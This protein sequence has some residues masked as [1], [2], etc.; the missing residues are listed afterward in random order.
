M[1]IVIYNKKYNVAGIFLP[2]RINLFE[3]KCIGLTPIA[4]HTTCVTY[5]S[6]ESQ[7]S[8]WAW[9]ISLKSAPTTEADIDVL[10]PWVTETSHLPRGRRRARRTGPAVP[11][12]TCP[13]WPASAACCSRPAKRSPRP[14]A[15]PAPASPRLLPTSGSR[16]GYY[17]WSM[18]KGMKAERE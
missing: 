16:W 2:V 11:R 5:L 17:H 3:E 15:P 14:A 7:P 10:R 1:T 4:G 6:S 12:D 8:Q 9:I 18:S 13:C